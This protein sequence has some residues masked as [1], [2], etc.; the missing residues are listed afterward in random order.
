MKHRSDDVVRVAVLDDYQNV[1]S[2]M[3]DWSP[4]AGRVAITVFNDHL[5]DADEVVERLL[6]FDVVCVM[7]ERT[8]LSREIIERLPRLKLI[9]S[10]GRRNA[11]IDVDAA[12][13]RGIVVTHT[14]Y[15]GTSTVELT[16]ALILASVRNIAEE[17][18]SLRAGGWQ[19]TVGDV[20]AA[21]T[22]G[23]L[24]LGNIGSEVA[25]IGR[26]FGM[27]VMAWSQNL[28][29]AKAQTCGAQ[30]VSKDELFRS[31]DVV[32]IHLV[33]SDRTRGLVGAAELDSMKPSARL[34]NTSRGPIVDESALI[35]AL[36]ERRFA[37]AAL[38]VF[39]T[40]PLPE[41]HPFRT[42]DNVLATPHIG[43]VARDLYRTFYG[44]TVKNIV[45]WLD[46]QG[47]R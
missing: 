6:P 11:A 9:A 12:A 27:L 41:N 2:Q 29:A 47:T 16:W 14:G 25:R 46:D 17:N 45:R 3:A 23:V 10:T 42:L 38:D 1:A 28:T 36:S 39:D 13:E 26:A 33:L 15:D 18:A 35:R 22:L 21:K 44:D 40:E 20:L 31:A 7:R 37:G 32:T 8:P 34:I 24:G 43:Y 19:S 5:S 4:L 30:L